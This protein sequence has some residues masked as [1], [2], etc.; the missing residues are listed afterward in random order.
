MNHYPNPTSGDEEMLAEID[1]LEWEA[2]Q[3]VEAEQER[4]RNE[5]QEEN[6]KQKE[7]DT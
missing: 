7:K 1:Y 4:A 3:E 5:E 2:Q 6:A